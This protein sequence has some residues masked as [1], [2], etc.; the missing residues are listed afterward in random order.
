MD[1]QELGHVRPWAGAGRADGQPTTAQAHGTPPRPEFGDKVVYTAPKGASPGKFSIVE[2]EPDPEDAGAVTRKPPQVS[3]ASL[4]D[5]L[6]TGVLSPTISART[7]RRR[8]PSGH[9]A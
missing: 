4:E 7:P 3:A 6:R 5:M 9:P 8:L 1:R 2:S